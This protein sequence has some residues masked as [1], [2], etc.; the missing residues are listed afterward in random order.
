MKIVIFGAS[1]K[2]GRWL[3]VQA[4]DQGHDVTAFVRNPAAFRITNQKFSKVQGD[5]MNPE[6]VGTAIS[7]KEAVLSAIGF[8]RK[9]PKTVCA[10]GT[11]NMIAAMQKHGVRRLI[12]ESAYGVGDTRNRGFYAR[13][14]SLIIQS[15]LADKEKME[16]AVRQSGLDWV[17]A[18]PTALTDGSKTGGY[19][20]GSNLQLGFWPMIS[21]AD[22]ANFMLKQITDTTFLRQSPTV[23]Y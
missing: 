23:S 6:Q 18:R 3:V 22:V 11:R 5:V 10:D 4:L 19:R 14:L 16:A 2:T 15:R 20:A 12:C 8:S 9:S 13:F 21:R 1:G 7:G 17:I